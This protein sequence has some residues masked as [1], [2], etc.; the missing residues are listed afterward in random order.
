M[1]MN[2]NDSV[3]GHYYTK[4]IIEENMSILHTLTIVHFSCNKMFTKFENITL[5]MTDALNSKFQ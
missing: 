4:K 2:L 1:T 3:M 5:Q